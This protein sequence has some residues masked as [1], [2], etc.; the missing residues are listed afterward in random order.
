MPPACAQMVAELVG[1][2]ADLV[3]VF[4]V[5]KKYSYLD[6]LN[7]VVAQR[8]GGQQ[9][10]LVPQECRADVVQLRE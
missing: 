7:V 10:V 9:N 8:L 3:G 4:Q 5:G 2:V 6:V 1:V